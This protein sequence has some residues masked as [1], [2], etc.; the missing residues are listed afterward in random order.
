M[1]ADLADLPGVAFNNMDALYSWNA[2]EKILQ[3]PD[4]NVAQIGGFREEDGKIDPCLGH[5]C[6]VQAP[7]KERVVATFAPVSIMFLVLASPDAKKAT[8]IRNDRME[9][10]R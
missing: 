3:P 5:R 8:G 2:N 10:V 1:Q 9:D 7:P 4:A 6:L